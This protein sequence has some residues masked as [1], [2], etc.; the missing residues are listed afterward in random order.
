MKPVA[1]VSRV[2]QGVTRRKGS[3]SSVCGVTAGEC[4]TCLQET[5]NID[6]LNKA[7]WIRNTLTNVIIR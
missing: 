7:V 6:L 5:L 2:L 3:V 1:V 4:F